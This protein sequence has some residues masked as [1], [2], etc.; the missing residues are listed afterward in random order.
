MMLDAELMKTC[1]FN[2]VTN[3]FQA[4]PEGG[5]L[6]MQT[7]RDDGIFILN[8][9][10]T[11]AGIAKENM[12]KIFEPFFTT[13]TNGL[14]LGLAITKRVIEEHGG[15]IEFSSIEREGSN[16]VIRLPLPHS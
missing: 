5:T 7:A 1:V 3:A 15:T 14:G 10:D 9:S 4:M 8:I 6:T 12:D 13:K 2:I 11:G 16:V